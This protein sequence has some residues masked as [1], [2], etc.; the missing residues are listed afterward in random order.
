MPITTGL[1]H[2]AFLTTD[3]DR[4]VRFYEQAFEARVVHEVPRTDDHPWLK[5]LDVGGGSMIN[6]FQAEEGD[7]FGERRTPGKR[8]GVDHFGFQADSKATLEVLKG[9]LRDAGAE[10]V[11]EIQQ[12][13]GEWSLFFRDIDGLELEVLAHVDS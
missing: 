1:N 4:T 13:G 10:E 6:V 9:R 8:G 5:I 3:M 12:L 7:V 2:V 11:G